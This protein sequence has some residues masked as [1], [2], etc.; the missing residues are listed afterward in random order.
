[1]VS[2]L[3]RTTSEDT[4]SSLASYEDLKILEYLVPRRR[5]LQNANCGGR[6][7]GLFLVSWGLS[8]S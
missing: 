3:F 7:S 4:I 6:A 8:V 1:M 2:I 5:K